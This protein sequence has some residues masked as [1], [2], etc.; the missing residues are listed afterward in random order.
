[1]NS[2]SYQIYCSGA[3]IC[4]IENEKDVGS[5]LQAILS[6]HWNDENIVIKRVSYAKV[7]DNYEEN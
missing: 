4:T 5:I 7:S 1:M 2:I 3:L 6:V